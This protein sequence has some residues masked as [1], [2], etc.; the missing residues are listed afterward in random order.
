M[1]KILSES[2]I[3]VKSIEELEKLR[4][5]YDREQIIIFFC[6]DCGKEVKKS[7]RCSNPLKCKYC[8]TKE[9]WKEK[10]GVENV[11]YLPEIKSLLSK[12]AKEN[13]KESYEKYK[14]LV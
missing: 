6:E 7:L 9:V 11:S 4:H 10:Y 12:K 13:S 2:P 1:S 8:K 5:L 3:F 14:K